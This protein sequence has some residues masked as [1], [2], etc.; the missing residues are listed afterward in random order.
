VRFGSAVAEAL[1][2]LAAR[3]HALAANRTFP[4]PAHVVLDPAAWTFDGS[5][6]PIVER[7]TS[8][9]E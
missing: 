5:L 2:D 3:A 1:H 6:S 9:A 8:N 7:R 4:H